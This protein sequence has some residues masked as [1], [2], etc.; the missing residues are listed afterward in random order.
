MSLAGFLCLPSRASSPSAFDEVQW[1]DWGPE[2]WLGDLP[3]FCSEVMDGI[4]SEQNSGDAKFAGLL[5]VADDLEE[6]LHVYTAPKHEEGEWLATEESQPHPAKRRRADAVSNWVP[7]PVPAPPA[8][9]PHA[10]LPPSSRYINAAWATE[11][12]GALG[13]LTCVDE[14]EWTIY[15]VDAFGSKSGS[16]G[17]RKDAVRKVVLMDRLLLALSHE[18]CQDTRLAADIARSPLVVPELLADDAAP[19]RRFLRPFRSFRVNDPLP[20]P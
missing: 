4:T 8:P 1:G 12:V 3:L 10:A 13:G 6:T 5:D 18:T 16:S 17:P 19:L 9:S 14:E 15:L 7:A 2:V 11:L 20:N